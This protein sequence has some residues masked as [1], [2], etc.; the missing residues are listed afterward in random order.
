VRAWNEKSIK[1]N[2]LFNNILSAFGLNIQTVWLW[3]FC[4]EN[5]SSIDKDKYDFITIK[6]PSVWKFIIL[7]L[8][9]I[10]QPWLDTYVGVFYIM[11]TNNT[12]SELRLLGAFKN[13][14]SST[15]VINND[16]IYYV[17]NLPNFH[18]LV[19]KN[20]YMCSQSQIGRG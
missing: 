3:N 16:Q 20:I 5:M 11:K 17:T 8:E 2:I 13:S 4:A 6:E 10:E 15:V 12:N 14:K 9:E 7:P 1:F 19:L 18:W